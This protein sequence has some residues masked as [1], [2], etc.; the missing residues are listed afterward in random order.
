MGP[1]RRLQWTWLGRAE[2]QFGGQTLH[3]STVQMWLLLNFNQTEEVAVEVLLKNSDLSPELLHQALLPLTSDNGLLTLEEAQNFPE[4]GLLR[5]RKSKSQT[6]EEVL[7]LIPPQTYLSVEKDE[8]RTLEQ[9]RNLLSC[10]LVRILKAHG[11]KG[12][13]IDQL[14]CLVLE[15]WQKGPNPPGS[16][17][18]SVAG[19]VACSSTDVL[20]CILHLLGQGYVERRDDRPQV[21]M[22]ATPEPMGPCRGQADVPLC[23]KLGTETS[24]PR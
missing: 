16:L 7:W 10:L 6:H 22:Y 4:G 21:L 23:G 20:S 14:V 2:L 3:V 13:H 17:G 24:K 11:E 1:H 9:K 12:L 18:C 5:L 8:G 15:A 19:G